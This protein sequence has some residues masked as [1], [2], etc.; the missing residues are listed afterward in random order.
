MQRASGTGRLS[1]KLSAGKTR[2]DRLFQAGCAKIRLPDLAGQRHGEAVLINTA[3]GLTG[4]DSL[5]WHVT[6]GEG[7]D[8]VVT[9]QACERVYRSLGTNADVDTTLRVNQGAHL[10][11]LP[12][13]TILF[14]HSLLKRSLTADLHHGASA[15]FVEAIVFGRA[16]MGE[17]AGRMSLGER[18]RIS[19]D[20]RLV[21]GEDL[22]IGPD[23]GDML[24][25]PAVS[26]G[27]I[28]IATLVFIHP[29]AQDYLDRARLAAGEDAAVSAWTVGAAPGMAKLVARFAAADSY[30]LRRRIVPVMTLLSGK[31]DLPRV[32]SL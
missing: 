27:C 21:H 31:V 19:V 1:M 11:W 2:I 23:A 28:A 7:T 17:M 3:G 13:E 18:W 12:Q 26:G 25:R 5:S 20:G 14:D 15:L 24:G 8:L 30:D 22:A 4:G 32:W 16:E 10:S 6:A 29:L 9:T